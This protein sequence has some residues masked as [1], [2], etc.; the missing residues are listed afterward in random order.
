MKLK[1]A[2]KKRFFCCCFAAAVML[3]RPV[4]GQA[5]EI[6]VPVYHMHTGTEAK[7]GGCYSVAHY[8][9]ESY[10]Y[11]ETHGHRIEERGVCV[12]GNPGAPGSTCQRIV[13]KTGTRKVLSYYSTACG[14]EESDMLALLKLSASTEEWSKELTL[15]A[16]YEPVSETFALGE[17]PYVWNDEDC[18][19]QSVYPVSANGTYTVQLADADNRIHNGKAEIAISNIDNTAPVIE[20]YSCSSTEW[21]NAPV[22]LS[23]TSA[24]DLQEDGSEGCGLAE[25][26]FL[27]DNEGQWC[28]EGYYVEGNANVTVAVRDRLGNT[29]EAV[30]AVSNIDKIAPVIKSI[31]CSEGT[32]LAQSTITVLAE[33]LQEDGSAG[34]GLHE[35]AYSWDGGKTWQSANTYEVKQ[36]GTYTVWVRDCLGNTETA[37]ITVEGIDSYGPEILYENRPAV[38]TN[39]NVAIVITVSDYNADGSEGVGLHDAPYSWD[40]GKTWSTETSYLMSANGTKTVLARDKHGNITKQ[41]IKIGNI[42]KNA[43]SVTLYAQESKQSG[44]GTAQMALTAAA[45]DAESGLASK[46]FSWDGGR[47]W[48]QEAARYVTDAGTYNVMVRDV[49]GNTASAG[50]YIPSIADG[51]EAEESVSENTITAADLVSKIVPAAARK[52][53]QDGKAA[54]SPKIQHTN[55]QRGSVPKTAVRLLSREQ[56]QS[57]AADETAPPVVHQSAKRGAELGKLLLCAALLL[58]LLLLTWLLLWLF[59]LSVKLYTKDTTGKEAALGRCLIYKKKERYF[60]RISRQMYEKS[61]TGEFKIVFAEL[62]AKWRNGS[63]LSIQ[64]EQKTIKLAVRQELSFYLS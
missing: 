47:T 62:F 6:S 39:Q 30:I 14:Q 20:D 8:R 23:V 54:V 5:K 56:S 45:S 63:P 12:C 17:L 37:Q 64:Y 48:T 31:Q 59:V 61:E 49:C 29:R 10:T 51:E 35:Q 21:T 40:G 28:D 18:S 27:W 7:G 50:I 22:Y 3:L 19:A 43:P 24:R 1:K 25:N 53:R 46:P 57:T 4:Y 9:T 42:D 38:W 44:R 32:N 41:N 33:D 16:S 15:Q 58:I 36:N 11:E 52:Q 2:W 55:L 13:T 60:I 26:P 34:C